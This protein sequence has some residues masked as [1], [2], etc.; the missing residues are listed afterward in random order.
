MTYRINHYKEAKAEYLNALESESGLLARI[1]KIRKAVGKR[2]FA[3][4]WE[5]AQVGESVAQMKRLKNSVKNGKKLTHAEYQKYFRELSKIKLAIR[6]IRYKKGMMVCNDRGQ[7]SKKNPMLFTAI[8]NCEAIEYAKRER[9]LTAF[10]AYRHLIGHYPSGEKET[11]FRVVKNP[12]DARI[13]CESSPGERYKNSTYGRK[14]DLHVELVIYDGW[15]KEI[16]DRDLHYSGI[17]AILESER[18]GMG[19]EVAKVRYYTNGRGYSVNEHV[20]Y[21]VIDNGL[22]VNK[23]VGKIEKSR[24]KAIKKAIELI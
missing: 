22:V 18:L 3:V 13:V 5:N 15:K 10:S 23:I 20:G 11:V 2:H 12:N 19:L 9:K 14:T 7:I 17:V 24:E 8:N 1:P 4:M 6:R 21:V 16:Y